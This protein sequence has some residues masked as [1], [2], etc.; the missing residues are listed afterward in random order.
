MYIFRAALL[1]HVII[2]VLTKAELK[3]FKSVNKAK[4]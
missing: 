3:F 2:K 1:I 4:N